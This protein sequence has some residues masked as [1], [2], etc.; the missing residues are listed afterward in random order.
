MLQPY[1][2]M[3]AHLI[4]PLQTFTDVHTD[5]Y[6]GSMGYKRYQNNPFTVP[7]FIDSLQKVPAAVYTSTEHLYFVT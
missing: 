1:R 6:N 4:I 2:Y 5:I 7:S 3:T